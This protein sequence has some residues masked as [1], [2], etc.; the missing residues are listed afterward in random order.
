MYD[1]EK[2][3]NSVA[4]CFFV[5]GFGLMNNFWNYISYSFIKLLS[6][7]FVY[8]I[9]YIDFNFLNYLK[10]YNLIC[11][12]SVMELS[13]LIFY[14]YK[15]H[16]SFNTKKKNKEESITFHITRCICSSYLKQYSN[17]YLRFFRKIL[18]LKVQK[19]K[20]FSE[21]PTDLRN[22]FETP[23]SRNI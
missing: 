11:S 1:I 18:N 14:N 12:C 8:F 15:F 7:I 6:H 4:F 3:H 13:N 20:T 21:V 19:Q 2:Q 9:L 23:K 5:C 10:F 22:N 16:V 17:I